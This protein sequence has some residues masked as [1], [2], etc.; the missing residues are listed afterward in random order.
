M[1]RIVLNR[2]PFAL[3]T[4]ANKKNRDENPLQRHSNRGVAF[5]IF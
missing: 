5:F 1:A 2:K 4:T 3:A